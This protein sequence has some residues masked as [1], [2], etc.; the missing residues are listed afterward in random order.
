MESCFGVL[1]VYA[2]VKWRFLEYE[3]ESS[4][5]VCI[6]LFMLDAGGKL[7][8]VGFDALVLIVQRGSGVCEKAEG[9]GV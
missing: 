9:N 6:M 7:W 2:S 3:L 8:R 5:F 4:S 1:V